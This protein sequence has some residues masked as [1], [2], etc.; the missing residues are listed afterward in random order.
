LW[1]W[2][3]QATPEAKVEVEIEELPPMGAEEAKFEE[4]IDLIAQKFKPLEMLLE[5][6]EEEDDRER[7]APITSSFFR[8]TWE[9]YCQHR[10]AAEGP[11]A[12]CCRRKL[13]R[14]GRTWTSCYSGN[15]FDSHRSRRQG[16]L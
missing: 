2:T 15:L 12:S 14:L 13:A 10:I 4:A 6:Y 8:R 11:H 1:Y 3:F 16:F 5:S 9:G 7:I